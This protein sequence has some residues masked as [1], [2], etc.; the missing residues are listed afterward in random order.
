[1]L[2]L[3]NPVPVIPCLQCEADRAN[4]FS[5]SSTSLS[6]VS[7]SRTCIGN[8]GF[9]RGGVIGGQKRWVSD[10]TVVDSDEEDSDIS[11]EMSSSPELESISLPSSL[12]SLCFV[13]PNVHSA[14]V[15]RNAF[16]GVSPTTNSTSHASVSRSSSGS[17]FTTT[18]SLAGS[19]RSSFINHTLTSG[20]ELGRGLKDYVPR[21]AA[22]KAFLSM[23][24]SSGNGSSSGVSGNGV[25]INNSGSSVGIHDGVLVGSPPSLSAT[26]INEGGV[27]FLRRSSFGSRTSGPGGGIVAELTNISRRMLLHDEGY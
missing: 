23:E 5:T 8:V 19:P 6:S 26:N 9:E 27:H 13:K 16:F 18:N 20:C 14:A 21:E 11:N 17:N 25:S 22:I 24:S 15:N 12:R 4:A 10:V 2:R 3:Q 7:S 1:M